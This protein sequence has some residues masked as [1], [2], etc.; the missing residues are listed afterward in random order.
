M[1]S[2]RQNSLE[3][4]EMRIFQIEKEKETF[5]SIL[6]RILGE[7][8]EW[9]IEQ[10]DNGQ[11]YIKYCKQGI[12][13]SSEGIGDGIWSVF[14]ICSALCDAEDNSTI[15]IDEPELSIHPALQR[16]IMRILEEYATRMQI[17]ISTHS[18]YFITWDAI[19]NGAGLIRVVKEG[20]NSKCYFLDD[21]CRNMIK[22]IKTDL[23]NPHVLGI[24]ANEVFF[25]EDRIILVEGQEDIVI[26]KKIMKEINCEIQGDFFG[27]GV[28]GA[29]KMD[30]FLNFF[31]CLGYKKVVAIFDGDKIKEEYR[32]KELY[33]DYHFVVLPEDD[34]RDKEEKYNKAK[35]GITNKKGKIKEEHTEFVEKMIKDINSYLCN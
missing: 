21:Y 20:V 16:R 33:P 11:Y 34:I 27:W 12:T 7:D 6:K 32:L 30:F 5:D 8:F 25:L 24:V 18:P 31:Q 3:M 10:H 9:S 22:G 4:F 26:Y 28:G 19:V 14:T 2:K 17:I 1:N 29:A 23:Y 15:V 13:H 35:R